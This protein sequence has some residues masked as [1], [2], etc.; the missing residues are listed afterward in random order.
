MDFLEELRELVILHACAQNM[1][2]AA[3]RNVLDRIVRLEPDGRGSWAFEWRQE[4]LSFLRKQRPLD[5]YQ[6]FNLARFPYPFT[7]QMETAHQE[8]LSAFNTWVNDIGIHCQ[9][10]VVEYQGHSI[11][12]YFSPFKKDAPLLLVM[13]GIVSLK[14]QWSGFIL[15]GKKLG[16]SVL[17][18]EMPGVGENPMIYDDSAY[19][20]LSAL[21]DKVAAQA[22]VEHTHAVM[23]S[24][25]GNLALRQAV[26]DKRIKAITT[27]GAPV[28]RFFTDDSWWRAVPE[29]TKNTLARLCRCDDKALFDYIARFAIADSEL[30]HLNTPVYYIRS[31]RDEIIPEAEVALLSRCIKRLHITEYDDV[32]GS[33]NYMME[34]QKLVPLTVL[35]ESG[36]NRV[37]AILLRCLLGLNQLRR[38]LRRVLRREARYEQ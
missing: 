21:I 29:T 14:E 16:M 6:Y 12:F 24:F 28:Q 3:C 10:Q 32:H 25:S 31:R 4:G 8:C 38:V 30:K 7:P 23:M 36:T 37:A 2:L 9:R 17:V 26:Q 22:Q 11:P 18:A 27:V 5:A 34:M 15:A 19:G 20:Y 13:G 35:R 33:P 1:N